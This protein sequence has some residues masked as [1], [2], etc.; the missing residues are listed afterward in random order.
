M[1]ITADKANRPPRLGVVEKQEE[2]NFSVIKYPHASS[3]I[4]WNQGAAVFIE[5]L[6]RYAVICNNLWDFQTAALRL[7]GRLIQRGH[8]ARLL[9]VTWMKYLEERWPYQLAHKYKMQEWFSVALAQLKGKTAWQHPTPQPRKRWVKKVDL[10]IPDNKPECSQQ[11]EQ[12]ST[13]EEPKT[14]QGFKETVEE[15]FVQDEDAE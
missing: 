13:P 2:W 6:I 1:K 11:M 8:K 3:N 4:P 14:G 9:V 10:A 5:Q 15:I 7:A 12:P